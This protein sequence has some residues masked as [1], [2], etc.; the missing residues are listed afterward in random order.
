MDAW[1]AFVE[2]QKK[3]LGESTVNKW[4]RPLKVLSFD[5]CNLY[6]QAADTFQAVWFKEHIEKKAAKQFVNNNNRRIKIHLS[7]LNEPVKKK[8]LI[9]NP[10]KAKEVAPPPFALLFE[11]LD[12][13]CTFSSFQITN[14]NMLTYKVF[15]QVLGLRSNPTSNGLEGFNPIYIYGDTGSGKT[16]LLMAITQALRSEGLRV[17]YVKAETFA[18]H[19]VSAIRAGE[20][21]L[22]RQEYR[23]IDALVVDDVH[24]LS[25]KGATQE[26]IFHT[27]NTLYT[28]GKQIILSANCA[29]GELQHIEPRLISRFEWGIVLP[30][31]P[32]HKEAMAL[33]L[34]EKAAAMNF[35]LNAKVAEFLLKSFTT[36]TAINKALEALI[37]RSHLNKLEGEVT[38]PVAQQ[39]LDDLLKEEAESAITPMHIVQGVA[40]FFGIRKEDIL[41]KVQ[42]R[43]RVLPRQLAM[44]LCRSLLKMPYIKIG[45]FFSKDHSTVMSSVK[46]IQQAIDRNDQEISSA[47][48]SILKR[49][50]E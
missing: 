9:V 43:D 17:I 50:R 3:E 6:L 7:I 28:M 15:L 19:V 25:R 4:L 37:L 24:L 32:P 12:P 35:S 31:E 48:R 10:K 45:D 26:E 49:I 20:M 42:T 44:Y 36:S 27:F 30:V 2:A 38:L 5:A 1:K 14:A 40:E 41:G 21:G 29:P 22:F 33:I 18:D 34:A 47:H 16:H 46:L 23:N 13:Y 8:R 39:L 11:D